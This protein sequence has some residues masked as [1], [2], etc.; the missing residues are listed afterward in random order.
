MF[1]RDAQETIAKPAVV[2][3]GRLINPALALISQTLPSEESSSLPSNCAV[4]PPCEI[5]VVIRL[6]GPLQFVDPVKN[7]VDPRSN[8]FGI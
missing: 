6:L 7:S 1:P 3:K 8:E 2:V 4:F 5:S